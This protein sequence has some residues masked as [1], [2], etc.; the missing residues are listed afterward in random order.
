LLV[1]DLP[2]IP[3]QRG[4]RI[5]RVMVRYTHQEKWRNPPQPASLIAGANDAPLLVRRWRA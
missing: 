2:R 4:D 5:L 3:R 1:A